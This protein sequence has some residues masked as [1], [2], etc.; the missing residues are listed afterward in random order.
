MLW[1]GAN[2]LLFEAHCLAMIIRECCPN[3]HSTDYQKNGSLPNGKQNHRCHDCGRQFVV[4]FEQRLVP[5]NDRELIK[6]LLCE[7]VS[8]QGICRVVGVGMTWLMGFVM[9]CY[10]AVPVD[11]NCRLPDCPKNVILYH[12]QAET[13]EL[14]SFVGTKANK[15]WLWLA[16]DRRTRQVLAFHVG[17]RSKKSARTLWKKLPAMYRQQATFWTDG[18]I[19]YH[20]VIPTKQHRVVSKKSRGTNRIERLNATL[21]QRISR[22]VRATL[23]FSKKL[24]NHIGAI[25][26]FLSQ[27]NL[28]LAKA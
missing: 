10:E 3:C 13:D 12:L 27:Y 8:L 7:R 18:Y 23:S 20:G 6:R 21:R 19:A 25:K 17:D 22:L 2:R 16:L 4:D 28:E 24:D 1:L 9:D 5:E 15:Q 26:Y 11:L 14:Q